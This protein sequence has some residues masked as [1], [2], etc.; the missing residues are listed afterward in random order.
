MPSNF[1]LH[2]GPFEHYVT[3]FSILSKLIFFILAISPVRFKPQVLHHFLGVV[4]LMFRASELLLQF[5]HVHPP[6]PSTGLSSL[7]VIYTI[8]H[9][10]Y[11]SWSHLQLCTVEIGPK[12]HRQNE[13]LFP[14]LLFLF[15]SP[16]LPWHRHSRFLGC[17]LW[18][19]DWKRRVK[20]E[21][22]RGPRHGKP[23]PSP[24]RE[25]LFWEL[26][27]SDHICRKSE[28]GDIKGG[29]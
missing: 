14:E 15:G 7:V 1:R 26:W 25:K 8:V 13:E 18:S 9:C 6:S 4:I 22:V 2:P 3:R 19:W 28:I 12:L 24:G 11:Q 27:L 17:W 20:T 10:V 29:K 16:L 21:R 5:L 23:F